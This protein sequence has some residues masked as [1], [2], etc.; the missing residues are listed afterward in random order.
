MGAISPDGRTLS[1]TDFSAGG[2]GDLAVRNLET[3]ESHRLTKKG[4]WDVPEF[5]QAVQ[6]IS[7]DG[8]HVA[9][10]WQGRSSCDLRIVD[11]DGSEPRILYRDD[12][13][14]NVLL[15]D[16]SRDGQHI[17]ATFS[18]KDGTGRIVVVS[19]A[20]GSAQVLKTF[21][22]ASG[23]G[24]GPI[25]AFSP[26]GRFVVYDARSNAESPNRDIHVLSV[27]GTRDSVLVEHAANDYVLGWAPDGNWV[28]FASDREGTLD[29]WG[30][31]VEDGRPRGLPKLVRSEIPPTEWGVFTRDGS[32]YYA[33]FVWA[34]DVYLTTIDPETGNVRRPD[35]LISHVGFNTAAE[36]S[37]DGRYLAYVSG[38]GRYPD[39]FVLGIH[40]VETGEAVRFRLELARWGGHAF[41][42]QWSPDG[43]A[44]LGSGRLGIQRIDAQTGEVTIV[45]I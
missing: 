1:Y 17:L 22:A 27:D 3:G 11:V 30:I 31:R 7:P 35:E 28:L 8:R 21:D 34:N 33:R 24:A 15:R 6:A 26:D 18:M 4:T 40:S 44:L 42:P 13:I 19:V 25:M 10:G 41:Q 16:W 23:S 14:A 37:R 20:D 9:Y 39:P 5:A 2:T 32:Y 38:R 29:V 36:W 43:Q 12:E 45:F